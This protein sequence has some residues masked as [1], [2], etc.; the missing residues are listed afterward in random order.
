MNYRGGADAFITLLT[1]DGKF[2]TY[3]TY[4]GGTGNDY[5]DGIVVHISLDFAAT[6]GLPGSPILRVSPLKNAV[7]DYRGGYDAFVTKYRL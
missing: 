6:F 2:L 3:S 1:N 7:Q 4:L 5:A